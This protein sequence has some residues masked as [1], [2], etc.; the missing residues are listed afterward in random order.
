LPFLE[1]IPGRS[2]WAQSN[3]PIFTFFLCQSCGVVNSDFW[4]DAAG[5][6]AGNLG[7]TAV[8]ALE[9]HADHLLIVRGVDFQTASPTGCG[10]AQGLS[11]VITGTATSGNGNSATAQG[12]SAD[13]TIAKAV[14]E[15]GAGPLTLYAGMKG[16]YIDD[17]LS[18]DDSGRVRAAEGNPYQV[19]RDLMNLAP[20]TSSGT[21]AT[22]APEPT[23][24][25][26]MEPD[27]VAVVDELAVRRNSVNDYVREELN[28]L[29]A[30][31]M[32][33]AADRERLELHFDNIRDIENT[34]SE[35]GMVTNSAGGLVP[36]GPLQG[37]T[38]DGLN[39]ADFDAYSDGRSHRGN[40]AQEDVSILHSQL[41]AF[42]FA[43]N[44]NRAASL[45][46]GD[47]TDATVYNVPS[48][49][50]GWGMHH[51][52]HR[53]QS[54]G[55]AGNDA[56]ALEAHKEIDALL[57]QNF[58]LILDKFGEYSTATGSLFNNSMVIWTN[59]VADGPS[60]RM[61]NVPYIIA[62]SGGSF[63]KQGEIIQLGS[64]GGGGG[65]FGGGGS[66]VKNV[67]LLDTI[68][69]AAGAGGTPMA[70]LIV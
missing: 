3:E 12:P 23:M 37:C 42:A 13:F 7:T 8:S 64:S 1:G 61:A 36:G 41:V 67:E 46:V 2:A 66:G 48:N 65:G 54:D 55:Q 14:N 10:H 27:T 9:S 16:G 35:M 20:A 58:A 68:K 49:A 47:G 40:G 57:M 25:A 17:R 69:A 31:T 26:M 52:S 34:M 56:T 21:V 18:F 15:G 63:L 70:E 33:S 24:P 59:H 38:M 28:N 60:H 29:K 50:R 62:G 11:Q 32:L 19:Y 30:Q 22:P 53:M 51:V 4:P 39:Q 6:I 5:P 44:L 45:Q 43:C